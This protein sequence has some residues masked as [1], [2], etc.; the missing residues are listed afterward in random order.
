MREPDT[1]WYYT[2]IGMTDKEIMEYDLKYWILPERV[3]IQNMNTTNYLEAIADNGGEFEIAYN[4]WINP[5]FG[6]EQF[7]YRLI[8]TEWLLKYKNED[9]D[10]YFTSENEPATVGSIAMF[11]ISLANFFAALI[12]QLTTLGN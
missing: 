3:F 6:A 12:V 8:G 4:D 2:E 7:I 1:E 11:V 10:S 5:A 9:R